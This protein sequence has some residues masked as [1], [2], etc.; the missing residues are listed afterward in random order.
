MGEKSYASSCDDR[1]QDK[2][3][4]EM[5][6]LSSD[7]VLA[8]TIK[9]F[10]AEYA[11][12]DNLEIFKAPKDDKFSKP[13]IALYSGR[14]LDI[15]ELIGTEWIIYANIDRYGRVVVKPCGYSGKSPE[16]RIL[17]TRKN[18]DVPEIF[19]L[20]FTGKLTKIEH[21]W[22]QNKPSQKG[23]SKSQA[24]LT[25]NEILINKTNPKLDD[26]TKLLL[27][28]N[29]CDSVLEVG[30]NYFIMTKENGRQRHDAN[31]DLVRKPTYHSQCFVGDI[32]DIDTK[33]ILRRLSKTPEYSK[34]SK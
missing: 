4:I 18:V 34:E 15:P 21:S 25:V 24:E 9:R 3:S 8:G 22:V 28:V 32:V 14:T 11:V 20:V 29:D 19:G 2:L 33:A 10:E 12:F 31:G 13:E 26:I 7:V 16:Q 1:I 6:F 23:Y 17:D 27:N 5:E 30:H